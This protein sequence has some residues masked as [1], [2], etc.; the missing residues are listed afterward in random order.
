MNRGQIS[1]KAFDE[2]NEQL[3]QLKNVK[4]K[5]ISKAI[6]E[7][8]EHGDLKENSAYHEARKEQSLNEA[9]IAGLEEKLKDAEIISE[10][11]RPKG[12]VSIGSKVK[13]Q[14]LTTDDINEYIIVSDLEADITQRKIS[15]ETPVGEAMLGAKKGETI[16]V[17]VPAGLLKLKVLEI[18]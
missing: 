15:S 12:I 10:V 7:A 16:E 1:Q 6:G 3:M 4:R 11:E 5:E 18:S 13:Y 14:N 8:R 17:L 9:K 2:L